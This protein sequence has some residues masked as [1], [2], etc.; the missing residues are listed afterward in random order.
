MK[1]AELDA[2]KSEL[3]ASINS[4]NLDLSS[5]YPEFKKKISRDTSIERIDKSKALFGQIANIQ[6]MS[7][8]KIMEVSS[9]SPSFLTEGNFENKSLSFMN[10]ST[11][12]IKQLQQMEKKIDRK[13]KSKHSR[14][15]ALQQADA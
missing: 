10:S 6:N 15:K 1:T 7:H 5:N 13:M 9:K 12:D 8:R 14:D 4:L 3:R 11:I 2:S